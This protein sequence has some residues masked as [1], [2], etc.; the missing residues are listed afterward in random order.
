MLLTYLPPRHRLLHLQRLQLICLQWYPW[1][2]LS[3]AASA[4]QSLLC[5]AVTM[6][7][8]TLLTCV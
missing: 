5:S 4:Q 7:N 3:L 1:P 6:F 2:A 8:M